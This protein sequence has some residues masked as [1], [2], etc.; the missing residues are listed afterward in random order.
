MSADYDITEQ[1]YLTN[2][3]YKIN[4]SF[5]HAYG[6]QDTKSRGELSIKAILNVEEE[7]LAGDYQEQFSV[8]SPFT[9]MYPPSP[10]ESVING[11]T[12]TKC[13]I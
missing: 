4:T 8:Y 9:Y 5:Q 7:R 13:P 2:K 3:T 12:I 11:M 10:T 6:H 1:I